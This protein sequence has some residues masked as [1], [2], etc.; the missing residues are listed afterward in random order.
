MQ[1]VCDTLPTARLD[2]FLIYNTIKIG[3]ML[4]RYNQI[5]KKYINKCTC[6]IS[7]WQGGETIPN[8]WECYWNIMNGVRERVSLTWQHFWP[9]PTSQGHKPQLQE[10]SVHSLTILNFNLVK[11]TLRQSKSSLHI[12][13]AET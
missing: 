1:N 10:F 8:V 12:M 2:Y 5:E 7:V 4:K 3:G 9:R 6:S 11:S 13:N